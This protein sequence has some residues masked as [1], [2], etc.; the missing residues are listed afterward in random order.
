LNGEKLI[1]VPHPVETWPEYRTEGSPFDR[2]VHDLAKNEFT[3]WDSQGRIATYGLGYGWRSTVVDPNAPGN[4]AID[5]LQPEPWRVHLEY[6]DTAVV[7]HWLLT[8]MEDRSGNAVEY[9]YGCDGL[10]GDPDPHAAVEVCL[11]DITYTHGGSGKA[12]RSVRF[13]WEPREDVEFGY[14]AGVKHA[15]TQRLKAIAMYA[16]AQPGDGEG[17][18]QWE[19]RL[20]YEYS[21]QSGRSELTLV[22]QCDGQGVCAWGKEFGWYRPAGPS[23]TITPHYEFLTPAVFNASTPVYQG[24]NGNAPSLAHHPILLDADGDGKSDLWL[25]DSSG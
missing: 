5:L 14:E 19:Y 4:P 1:A 11:H 24:T 21:V 6:P 17:V 25:L 10:I 7:P 3:V 22:R 8:R 12:N 16:P 23:L 15:R 9:H 2:I 18:L 20:S 13:D